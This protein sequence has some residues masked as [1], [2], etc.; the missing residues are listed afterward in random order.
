[1]SNKRNCINLQQ[2]LTIKHKGVYYGHNKQQR[3]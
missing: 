3:T 2:H 1:M